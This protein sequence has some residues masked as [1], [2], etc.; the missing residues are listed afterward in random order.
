M[1]VCVYV[2]TVSGVKWPSSSSSQRDTYYKYIYDFNYYEGS[3]DQQSS[4]RNIYSDF[5]RTPAGK[6]VC[7]GPTDF[8]NETR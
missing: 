6:C 7:I 5:E 3:C 8:V 2:S 1:C 4:T